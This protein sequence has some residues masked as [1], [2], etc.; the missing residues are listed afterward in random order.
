M[1]PAAVTVIHSV[2]VPAGND[3]VVKVITTDWQVCAG[4]TTHIVLPWIDAESH[5]AEEVT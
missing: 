3:A 2:Y 5:E 1:A 4:L